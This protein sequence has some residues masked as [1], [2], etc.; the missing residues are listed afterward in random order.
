MAL[1]SEKERFLPHQ[2]STASQ[3]CGSFDDD[4]DYYDLFQSTRD[5]HSL[6]WWGENIVVS[7]FNVIVLLSTAISLTLCVNSVAS[8]KSDE[9]SVLLIC[10]IFAVILSLF[11]TGIFKLLQIP[12]CKIIFTLDNWKWICAVGIFNFLAFAVFAYSSGVGKTPPQLQIILFGLEVPLTVLIR[13]LVLK[14]GEC[15]FLQHTKQEHTSGPKSRQHHHQFLIFRK[16]EQK[17]T[18]RNIYYLW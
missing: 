10:T 13:K 12:G 15:N 16:Q 18:N 3:T 8:V 14:Q 1:H 11:L 7:V 17:S 5:Y 2:V 4:D 6:S 9:Y